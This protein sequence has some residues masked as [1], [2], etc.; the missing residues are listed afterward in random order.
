MVCERA[1]ADLQG[2]IGDLRERQAA[3][4]ER[5]DRQFGTGDSGLPDEGEFRALPFLV[6]PV[7]GGDAGVRPLPNRPEATPPVRSINPRVFGPDGTLFPAV[8]PGETYDLVCHLRNDGDMDLPPLAV[9]FFVDHVRGEVTLDR[10]PGVEGAGAGIRAAADDAVITGTTTLPPGT[11]FVATTSRG[12]RS[13]RTTVTV[14]PYR[15]FT[16]ER[17]F[18]VYDPG[19]QVSI[20]LKESLDRTARTLDKAIVDLVAGPVD[21]RRPMDLSAGTSAATFVGRQ[22]VRVPSGRRA[23]ATVPFTAPSLSGV[24]HTAVYARAYSLSPLDAPDAW[25]TL[26]PMVDRQVARSEV[27]WA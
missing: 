9:E 7:S 4:A 24:G 14:G 6:A 23:T 5:Y 11:E 15:T 27:Y 20:V 19:D 25:G 22:R 17:R 8:V 10:P 16:V 12:R 2:A 13:T 3:N 21:D 1:I 18:P 26:D